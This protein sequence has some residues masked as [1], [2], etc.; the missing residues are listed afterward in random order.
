VPQIPFGGEKNSGYARFG[1]K[2][3][4]EEFIELCWT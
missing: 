3:A 2:A 1:G 4:L